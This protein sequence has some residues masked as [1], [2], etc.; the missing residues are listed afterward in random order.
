MMFCRYLNLRKRSGFFG[1]VRFLDASILLG[2]KEETCLKSPKHIDFNTVN[3]QRFQPR[4]WGLFLE[5]IFKPRLAAPVYPLSG[6]FN[7]H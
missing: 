2:W 3:N 5:G 4:N 7:P 1:V 6:Y